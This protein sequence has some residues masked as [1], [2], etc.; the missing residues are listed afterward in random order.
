LKKGERRS[1]K[2]K[3]INRKQRKKD[4]EEEYKVKRGEENV[5]K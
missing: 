5:E 4:K 2:K 1:R 3:T